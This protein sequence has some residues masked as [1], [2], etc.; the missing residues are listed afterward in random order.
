MKTIELNEQQI[1]WLNTSLE[2]LE[3]AGTLSKTSQIIMEQILVKLLQ[4]KLTEE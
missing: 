4:A 1:E 3:K 2:R